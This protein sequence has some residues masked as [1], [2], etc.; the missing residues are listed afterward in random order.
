MSITAA[1][2]CALVYWIIQVLDPY[3]LSWQCLN[4]PIVV[5]PI[6][7]LVLGDLHTG[8]T[9]GA[10]LEA[11]FMGISAVGGSIPS[12]TLSGTIIS[13]SYAILVGGQ[14]ATETG[15]ALALSIGTVMASFN[16]MLMAVWSAMAAFWE[17]IAAEC[18]PRKFMF[19]SILFNIIAAL[20]GAII[21]FFGVAFGIDG[22]N[23]ALSALP[24]WVM[25]GLAAAGTMMTAVG[26]GI[27]LSMIWSADIAVFY[28]VGFIL[29]K[30]LQLSSL[31]IA[32]IGA[33][34]ALTI[35]FIEK[36]IVDAKKGMVKAEAAAEVKPAN[37]EEDFF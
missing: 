20:P 17:K 18:K 3:T 33:A 34:I 24:A 12:D 30:S 25:T 37:S 7:G 26:F 8:I 9:M 1:I 14:G 36:N 28:F 21:I 35:F 4:R 29:A 5:G 32:V 31:G 2:A 15:L 27:L 10:S 16:N 6:I 22:L 19:L 23:A 13:V 11:I